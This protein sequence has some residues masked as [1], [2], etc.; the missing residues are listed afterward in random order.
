MEKKKFK[1]IVS[2]EV[3]KVH[4]VIAWRKAN[5]QWLKK[6]ML[7]SI[8]ILKVLRERKISQIEFAKELGVS[9]QYVNK[10][11]KGNENLTLETISKIESLLKITLISVQHYQVQGEYKAT[12]SITASMTNLRKNIITETQKVS[13][14]KAFSY[15]NSPIEIDS[16]A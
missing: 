5:R 11:L 8:S 4:E 13:A 6:S 12:K 7:I 1:D 14:R 10:M 16:A 15:E 3:S 9:A 2:S